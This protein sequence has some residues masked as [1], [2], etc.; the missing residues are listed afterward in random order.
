LLSGPAGGAMAMADLARGHALPNLVGFDMG[1]TSSDVSVV[2]DGAVGETAE[3]SID[4]L[5]VRLPMIEIRTIGAGGGSI[6]RLDAGALRVGPESA[7]AVPGPVCYQRGGE[8]PAVTDANAVLGRIDPEAFLGGGMELDVAGARAALE[9]KIAEPLGLCLEAAAEGILD[10]ATMH[11][12]AAIRL[13]LFE[14]GADPGDFALAPF[15]G[16]AGLHACAVADELSMDR[17]VFPADASTLS[18]RG[19]LFADL[20]HDLS[21]SELLVLDE[22]A[23]GRRPDSSRPAADRDCVRPALPGAGV[24]ADD[25]VA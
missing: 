3:S 2:I 8:M 25:A 23:V 22:H 15:G 24:R 1:G 20:R 21:I 17:I 4:G 6:A 14:K 19:I 18:A 9:D 16:A 7:G 11:M 13:S 5:P 12:A 10:V